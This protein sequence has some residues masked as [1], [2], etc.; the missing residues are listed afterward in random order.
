MINRHTLP[1]FRV[2][3]Q[4]ALDGLFA[5]RLAILSREGPITPEQVAHDGTKV[6]AAASGQS[7]H[8]E[9]TLRAHLAAAQQRVQAMGDPREEAADRRTRGARQRAGRERMERTSITIWML[10]IRY[11]KSIVIIESGP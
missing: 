6:K 3:Q 7:F 9:P 5:P 4:E 11:I 2:E 1:D 10:T 8:R